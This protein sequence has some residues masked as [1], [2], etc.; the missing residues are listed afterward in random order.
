M[1]QI[2]TIVQ[3]ILNILGNPTD[4]RAQSEPQ[5]ACIFR[6]VGVGCHPQAVELRDALTTLIK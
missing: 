5:L 2:N 4:S 1:N 6:T 3:D